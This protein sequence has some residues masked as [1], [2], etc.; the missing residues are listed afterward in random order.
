MELV[1]AA[2]GRERGG[3]ALGSR[4]GAQVCALGGGGRCNVM[5][6]ELDT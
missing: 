5:S 6:L 1:G 2:R 3:C 4:I